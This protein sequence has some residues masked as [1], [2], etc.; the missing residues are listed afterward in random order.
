[1]AGPRLRLVARATVHPR[2]NRRD[3]QGDFSRPPSASKMPAAVSEAVEIFN[4]LLQL[5]VENKA[6]DIHVKSGKPAYLR[7]HGNLEAVEMEAI[8]AQQILDFVQASVPPQFAGDWKRD[9]QVDYC[10]SLEERGLGR[11]RA[12]GFFQRGQ[13]SMVFRHIKDR[14]PTFEQLNFEADVLKKLCECNDGII[15]VCGATGSGKSSTLAAMLNHLNQ[16]FDLHIV[17]LEDPIEYMYKDIKCLFNQREV[18][19]DTPSFSM[20]LKSVLRQD[21]DVILIGEMRDSSTFETALHAAETGHLVFGTLHAS[22]AQQAVQRLFDFFP[23]EQQMGMRR[24]VAGCLKATITQKLVPSIEGGG[25]VP[26]VELFVVDMLARTTIQEGQFEKIP[27]VIE[28]GADVGSKSFNKD[29]Y[30]L[31]KDGKISKAVGLEV[32][33]NPKALEMN[34]KGIFLSS[35]GIVG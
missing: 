10:Y 33:P 14:P 22:N 32:S 19:I 29:L 12:N 2:A 28:A 26:V 9:F 21:P 1:M 27:A 3:A 20:G 30:R 16:N 8:T 24:T 31:I 11:F 13:P 15:L 25:R 35:G 23:P 17:T 18:G 5:A 4:S 34:L 7:L 6:S